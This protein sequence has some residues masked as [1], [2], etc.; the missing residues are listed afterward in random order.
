MVWKKILFEVLKTAA[1][2]AQYTESA[3]SEFTISGLDSCHGG[4]TQRFCRL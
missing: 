1:M 4:T 2:V 3:G